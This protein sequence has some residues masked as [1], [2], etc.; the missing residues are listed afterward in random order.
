MTRG[1]TYGRCLSERQ[2]EPKGTEATMVLSHGS[3]ERTSLLYYEDPYRQETECRVVSLEERPNR[4]VRIELDRT[5]FFPEGGGQPCDQGEV[6]TATG[7]VKVQQVRWENGR[8]IHQGALVGSVEEGQQ[9][10]ATL[11]WGHRHRNMRVHSAGHLLHDVL[12]TMQPDLRPTKGNHGDKAYLEYSGELDPGMKDE[13]ER[14]VNE[15]VR[16]DLP[17]RTWESSYDEIAAMCKAVPF[18]LPKNKRLR[19]LRIGDNDPMPDGGVHVMSTKEIGKVVV[20]HIA[21]AEGKST[22]RYGVGGPID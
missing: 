16:A 12:M 6:Y 5:I 17:I 10:R 9:A 20:H 3:R 13:L 11:K 14:R 2:D 1:R 15:A 21:S 22:I 7:S 19:V 8:V 4:Q 18:N